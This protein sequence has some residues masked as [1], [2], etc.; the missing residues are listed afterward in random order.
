MGF[1]LV[2]RITA[3]EPRHARGI[4][5]VSLSDEALT[6][7]FPGWPIFPGTLVIESMA[8]LAGAML[9]ESCA[10]D[11]RPTTLSMLVGVDRARFRREIHPGDQV[12]LE[13]TL[14][15]QVTDGARVDVTATV[16]GERAAEATL[17]FVLVADRPSDFVADRAKVR[18][19][20][21]DGRWFR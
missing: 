12:I 4:K 7:H 19:L 20:L 10:R 6:D 15:Q 11:A 2:D 3:L 18:A 13:A 9:D 5:C 8:Q 16:E 14:V 17:S 21:R 1:V